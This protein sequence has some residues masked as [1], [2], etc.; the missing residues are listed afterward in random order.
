MTSPQLQPF[1]GAGLGLHFV[2]A[3]STPSDPFS[4]TTMTAEDSSTKLGWT[5]EVA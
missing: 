2:H 3:R 5:W 1:A 4:G